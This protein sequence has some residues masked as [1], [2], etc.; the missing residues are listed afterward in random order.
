MGN[1]YL[2]RRGWLDPDAGAARRER[3]DETRAPPRAGRRGLL[4]LP[5]PRRR[6]AGD[7]EHGRD[8]GDDGA[9]RHS[10]S[11]SPREGWVVVDLDLDLLVFLFSLF[12]SFFLR[13]ELILG[14]RAG[15]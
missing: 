15:L 9:A 11:L 14:G 7:E 6:R 13:D 1:T 12:F 8:G 5:T 4:L 10:L 3:V 2:Y